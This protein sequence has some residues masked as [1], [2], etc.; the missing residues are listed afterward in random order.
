MKEQYIVMMFTM[1]FLVMHN[2]NIQT[3]LFINGY[4]GKSILIDKIFLFITNPLIFIVLGLAALWIIIIR[5][6]YKKDPVERLKTMRDALFFV[7]SMMLVWFVVSFIK[8]VV[9]SPRPYQYFE[10]VK[11]LIIYGN[12]DSFPSLHAAFSFALAFLV[13]KRHR[14]WGITLFA[15][16]TLVGL[17]RVFVGAHFPID[18]I[19]GVLLGVF[20]PWGLS[21]LIRR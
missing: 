1:S 19:V 17:S 2:L 6:L 12:F 5:P 11:T 14:S 16:A 21:S 10:G 9:A 7:T 3:F 13:F 15:V 20:I 4:A 18:V 8:S